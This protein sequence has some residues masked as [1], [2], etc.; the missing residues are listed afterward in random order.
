MKFLYQILY[1]LLK[2]YCKIF[3]FSPYTTVCAIIK[4]NNRLL[5]IDHA[6]GSGHALP[7]GIVKYGENLEQALI[8][9][10]WEE[11]GFHAKITKQLFTQ[12]FTPNSAGTNNTLVVYEARIISGVMKASNEGVPNFFHIKKLPKL[13][14]DISIVLKKKSIETL[15]N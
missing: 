10:V 13:N 15:F 3:Y 12:S 1:K 9:E 14:P 6:D 7:G 11:T 2:I 4:K 5:L 8:R